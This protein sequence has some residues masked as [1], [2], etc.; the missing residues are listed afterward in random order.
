SRPSN[1]NR[2]Q[3]ELALSNLEAGAQ[4]AAFSSG[5]AATTAVFQA[6]KPGDHVICSKGFYG[7]RHLLEDVFEPWGLKVTLMDTTDLR[8]VESAL[9]PETRLIWAE[10]P[11]NPMM[12]VTDIK[13]IADLARKHNALSIFDNTLAS[14][15]LQRPLELGADLV[16]HSTTKYLGGHS[17][18]LGG[19]IIARE[20]SEFFARIRHLQAAAGAVPSPFE[21]WLLLR[22]IR[23]LALRVRTQAA[24]A[25]RIAEFLS[26][27]KSVESVLY[28]GLKSHPG[29]D[30]AA[31]QMKG[32]FGGLLSFLVKG[33]DK[34]ALG[35]TAHLRIITRATSLGA[36]ESTVDHRYSVEPPG[37]PTPKN[38]L[39]L[40]VGIEHVDDLIADLDQALAKM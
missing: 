32:G 34:D 13:G 17:D 30:V 3:L 27:H 22:G 9:R 36:V 35:M 25:Q 33:D 14:P 15:V 23:T 28:A 40:S 7:T 18:I 38:L 37:T 10:T 16:M 21:C 39:R 6:L 11:T 8:A 12:L 1:P 5:S 19:A 24:S 2:N 29:H 4:A 31:R 26:S 20:N